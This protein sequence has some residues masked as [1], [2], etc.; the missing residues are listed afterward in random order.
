MLAARVAKLEASA[1]E[2]YQHQQQQQQQ[3]QLQ[4]HSQRDGNGSVFHRHG[5]HALV[6]NLLD[7]QTRYEGAVSAYKRV[8][9]I[10]RVNPSGAQQP[11]RVAAVRASQEACD[12]ELHELQAQAARLRYL[13]SDYLLGHHGRQSLW[14]GPLPFIFNEQQDTAVGSSIRNVSL[15]LKNSARATSQHAS[16]TPA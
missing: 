6:G 15:Y 10:D 1:I 4:Q 11:A 8:L 14:M 9:D 2:R 7:T 5:P 16:F 13:D 3:Q 12:R